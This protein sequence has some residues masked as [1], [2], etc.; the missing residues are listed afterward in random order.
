MALVCGPTG[1]GKTLIGMMCIVDGL[2][3]M[4]RGQ[5]VLAESKVELRAVDFEKLGLP[6]LTEKGVGELSR[7]IQH[8]IYKGFIAPAALYAVLGAVL[9]RNRRASKKNEEE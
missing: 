5:S 3:A 6:P 9:W 8:G 2:R 1:S 7:S 4:Q